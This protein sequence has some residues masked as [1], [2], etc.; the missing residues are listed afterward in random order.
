MKTLTSLIV[1]ALSMCVGCQTGTIQADAVDGT[2]RRVAERHDRYIA[3]DPGL[4]A[5]EKSVSL[6]DTGLLRAVL[7]AARPAPVK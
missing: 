3:A 1:L 5:V 6:R 2:F 4:S 7:D